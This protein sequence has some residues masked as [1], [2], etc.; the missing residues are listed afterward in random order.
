MARP[1]DRTYAAQ[2]IPGRV[3]QSMSRTTGQLVSLYY[4]DQAGIEADH[5]WV[6]VCETHGEQ[7][8]YPTLRQAEQHIPLGD[9]CAACMAAPKRTIKKREYTTPTNPH[10]GRRTSRFVTVSGNRHIALGNEAYDHL[11]NPAWIAVQLKGNEV[12]LT[13]AE[14][15]EKQGQGIHKATPVSY[16]AVWIAVRTFVTKHHIANGKYPPIMKGKTVR[17]VPDRTTDQAIAEGAEDA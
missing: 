6:V 5:P 2:G 3:K 8:S 11:G 10:R 14:E 9:W 13:A 12:I 7:A 4:A 1:T 15:P 17:F 16:T